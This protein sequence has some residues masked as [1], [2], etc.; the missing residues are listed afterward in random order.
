[1]KT[2]LGLVASPRKFGNCEIFVKEVYRRLEGSWHLRLIRLPELDIRPCLACYQCLFGS[3]KC[4]QKDDLACVLK[5]MVQA[6]GILVAVPT[7]FL[8]ANASLKRLLD[9]GLSFYAHLENLWGKPAVG[10]AI[11]GVKGLEGYT[12]LMVDSFL[13]LILADHRGS[14]VVYGALPGEVLLNDDGPAAAR[15]LAKALEHRAASPDPHVPRCPL[16]GGDTFRFLAHQGIN[17]SNVRRLRCMTCSSE[18]TLQWNGTSFVVDTVRGEH[19]LFLTREDAVAHR[20]WLQSMKDL[21]LE[22]REELKGVTR[23]YKDVG[24][25]VRP[26]QD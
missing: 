22:R 15:R 1:M 16:C 14:E 11:A 21:F 10:V 9:R 26:P 13:K 19:P 23:A 12:K 5:E 7:Y 3:M 25:W 18:G 17:P 8:G 6:D 24:T 20:Q 2:L 4:V